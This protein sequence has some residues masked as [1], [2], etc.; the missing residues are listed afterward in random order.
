MTSGELADR[1]DCTWPTT[2]RHLRVLADAGLLTTTQH[3]R[4]RHYHLNT[5]AIDE[6]A[7]TWIDRFRPADDVRSR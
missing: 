4:R 3:G 6:I 1:F 5:A 7:G 2:T